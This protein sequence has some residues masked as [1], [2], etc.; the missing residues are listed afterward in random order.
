MLVAGAPAVVASS[1]AYADA[2]APPP[3]PSNCPGPQ[4][5]P[6]GYPNPPPSATNPYVYDG[7]AYSGP[8]PYEVPFKGIIAGGQITLPPNVKIPNLYA[9]ICG[10]V[11]LPQL[12]GTIAPTGVDLATPNVYV[13][14]LEALPAGVHFGTLH[15][16][17]DPTPAHNGGLDITLSGPTTAGV[18]TLGMTCSVTLDATFTTKSDGVLTGR[19]VTGPTMAGVAEVVSNSF[20]VP[21]VQASTTCPPSIALTFNKLLQLPARPG[22]GTFTTPFCFDFELEYPPP[23]PL[24]P[25]AQ[26][27]WPPS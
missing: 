15:A 18:T 13:A 25:T 22:V 3:F 7:K 12:S 23:K 11:E 27:P 24:V 21:A 20:P 14:G 2:H 6:P 19:P 16:T 17:I 26:C 1:P 8:I 9:S 10:L 4:Y 5:P